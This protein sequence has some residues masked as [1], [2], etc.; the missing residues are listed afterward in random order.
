METETVFVIWWV[1]IYILFPAY[2]YK[3]SGPSAWGAQHW[4]RIDGFEDKADAKLLALKLYNI[5]LRS[6]IR[7]EDTDETQEFNPGE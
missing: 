1:E 5:G 6:R 3:P 2:E 4:H 7:N